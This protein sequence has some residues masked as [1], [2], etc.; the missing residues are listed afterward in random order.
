[1][2]NKLLTEINEK[3]KTLNKVVQDNDYF[4]DLEKRCD[5]INN[6]CMRLENENTRLK[7]VIKWLKKYCSEHEEYELTELIDQLENANV[8]WL[9]NALKENK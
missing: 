1:M 8:E 9:E 4:K 3:M 2:I 6:R 5:F 7:Y